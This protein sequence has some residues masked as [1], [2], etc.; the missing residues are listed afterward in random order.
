M[1]NTKLICM[2]STKV[3]MVSRIFKSIKI[4]KSQKKSKSMSKSNSI[5][6]R[7][8]NPKKKYH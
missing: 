7:T 6:L 5:S 4:V 2:S 3:L 8:N 1:K